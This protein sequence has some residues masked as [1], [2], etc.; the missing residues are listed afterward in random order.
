LSQL[1]ISFILLGA[2]LAVFGLGSLSEGLFSNEGKTQQRVWLLFSLL[3]CGAM[4]RFTTGSVTRG[5][6]TVSILVSVVLLVSLSFTE[7]G[8]PYAFSAF[9]LLYSAVAVWLVLYEVKARATLGSRFETVLWSLIAVLILGLG[10]EVSVRSLSSDHLMPLWI[11]SLGLTLLVAWTLSVVLSDL[12]HGITSRQGLSVLGLGALISL[13]LFVAPAAIFSMLLLLLAVRA[14]YRVLLGVGVASLL[15]SMSHF[16]YLLQF[17]LLLKSMTL[18]IAGAIMLVAASR[19]S[20]L[21]G[22]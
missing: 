5:A 7:Q 21:S 17:S 12:G 6:M 22:S 19:L 8:L 16:Y 2:G 11:L 18:I 4:G 13:S 1:S 14:G 3:V 15:V 10:S 9:L 20:K